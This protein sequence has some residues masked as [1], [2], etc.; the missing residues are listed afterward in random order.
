MAQFSKAMPI[1]E[2]GRVVI[3]KEVRDAIGVRPGDDIIFQ[4]DGDQVRLT[5]R[6]ALVKRLKGIFKPDDDRDHTEA[7]LE[8]RRAE[9]DR[10]WS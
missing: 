2:N 4:V 3:P 7:F 5:T 1:N 8:D 6:S 10:K 9:A